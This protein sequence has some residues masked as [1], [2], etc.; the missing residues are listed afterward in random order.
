MSFDDVV[1]PELFPVRPETL[2][3]A[4]Q[5]TSE[6][7]LSEAF[8]DRMR[9]ALEIA[10]LAT[11]VA[12]PGREAELEEAVHEFAAASRL[13]PG[14]ISVEVYRSA[15][16]P[17]VLLLVERVAD[18]EVLSRHMASDYFRRLQAVQA[19]VLARPVEASFYA[20]AP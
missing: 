7:P 12:K 4:W 6:A 11:M 5:T 18:R 3:S 15:V 20:P 14:M 19:E 10:I 1:G 16:D 17:T 8:R 2:E 9:R 13:L